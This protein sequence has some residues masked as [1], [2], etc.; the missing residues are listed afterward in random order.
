MSSLANDKTSCAEDAFD[1]LA[2]A[3][4]DYN[5][6]KP[7][8]GKLKAGGNVNGFSSTNT[9]GNDMTLPV[10]ALVDSR[11]QHLIEMGFDSRLAKRAL[12]RTNGDWDSA[13]TML[14]AGMVPEEDEFDLLSTEAAGGQ[15]ARAGQVAKKPSAGS[16][17]P[18]HFRAG[19]AP[20]APAAAMVDSR[21]QQLVEMG[22]SADDAEKALKVAKNDFGAAVSLLT[23]PVDDLSA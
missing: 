23:N 14:T 21:I 20:D 9:I 7:A 4:T 11:I 19:L 17:G 18:D 3:P 6:V 12:E 1:I 2:E 5:V 8:A 22:F 15:A 10:D 13:V 16:E